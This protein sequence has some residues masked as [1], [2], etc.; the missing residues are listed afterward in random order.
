M[1]IA[2]ERH[3]GSKAISSEIK[4]YRKYQF[5]KKEE[6]GTGRERKADTEETDNPKT[7]TKEGENIERRT[8]L[9]QR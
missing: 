6:K 3:N 2:T 8:N 4:Y 5:R 1:C 7:L 9:D